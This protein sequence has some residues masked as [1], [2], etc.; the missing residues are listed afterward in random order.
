MVSSQPIA[1]IAGISGQDGS[2]MAEFLLAKG[3]KVFGITRNPSLI[4]TKNIYHLSDSITLLYS[5]Y[6]LY[7]LIDII[8]KIRPAEIYNFAGQSYVS[9]S[10]EM[11]EETIHSQSVL[12]SRFLEAILATNPEIRLLNSSSSEVFSPDNDGRIRE[13]S[14][15]KPYNPYGCSK[16]FAHCMVDAYRS[17]RGIFAVNAILF[18]HESPRRNENFAFKKIIN[19][20]VAIKLGRKE[21]L[22][23]G[24]LNVCRDWGYAPSYV[25]AMHMMLIGENPN[26]YCLCT[27]QSRSVEAIVSSAFSYLEMDWREFVDVDPSLL[28]VNEPEDIVGDP[29]KA[30]T[31]LGWRA[32]PEF[33]DMIAHIIEFE[34]R[35]CSGR[36]KLFKNENPLFN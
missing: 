14:L 15:I 27:G 8:N 17:T 13:T 9:K 7:Q 31:I 11:V 19:T 1:L 12:T 6:E 36:E 18:P 3:Y 21:R 25:Y 16:A 29:V 35:V 30:S 33:E 24:N 2:Y 4:L 22:K 20:A 23:I 32:V 10:W 26:N 28:R 5:S 34:F